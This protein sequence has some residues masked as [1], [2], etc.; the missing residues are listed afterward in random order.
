MKK[1][2]NADKGIIDSYKYDVKEVFEDKQK[3]DKGDNRDRH[4][5]FAPAEAMYKKYFVDKEID[6]ILLDFET[7]MMNA[8]RGGTNSRLRKEGD[9]ISKDEDIRCSIVQEFLN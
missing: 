2:I 1:L 8:R 3:V 7:Y 5:N 4:G 9:V 6:K